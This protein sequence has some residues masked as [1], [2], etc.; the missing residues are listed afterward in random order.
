MTSGTLIEDAKATFDVFDQIRDGSLNNEELADMVYMV[1]GETG[2][3]KTLI[4]RDDMDTNGNRVI[5]F[6]E[7]Y[8]SVYQGG[9]GQKP[10]L[11]DSQKRV[12]S[13]YDTNNNMQIDMV[14]FT[15][16]TL[17]LNSGAEY[18]GGIRPRFYQLDRN[19][20]WYIDLEEFLIQ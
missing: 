3:M 6:E 11:S 4:R 17:H 5:E 1:Y 7:Y 12:F 20:D 16:R 13:S 15:Y 14:E 18:P 2:L 9:S 19:I 10:N 8:S